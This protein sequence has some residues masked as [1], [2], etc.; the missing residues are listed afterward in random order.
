MNLDWSLPASVSIGAGTALFVGGTCF[1]A[2]AE[3]SSLRFVLDGHEQGV[4][5]HGM[6]RLD[7]LRA[8]HPAL[9]L[10][11]GGPLEF[12]PSS[13][14]DP[15][16]RSYRSGFWGLVRIGPDPSDSRLDLLLRAELD[17]GVEKTAS[18]ATIAVAARTASIPDAS[19]PSS[20]A[21]R[22]AICMATYD[23]PLDLFQR[24]IDSIRAQTHENWVCLISDD[25]SKPECS[26]QIAKVI[27]GDPRFVLSSSERRQ[28][29]YLNFERALSMV[30]D[31]A[32]HVTLA[33]Q[34]DFWYPEKLETLLAGMGGAH[35]IYSDARIVGRRGEE[36]SPTYWG[37]RRRNHDDLSALLMANC[38]TG[39]A[40][41]FRREVLT[42]ALPFP[43]AQFAHYH[44]HWL[45][46]VAGM[47]GRIDFIDRPLYDYVQHG[48]SALGHA[49]ATRVVS[50]RQ[51]AAKITG[52]PHER[53][54]FYRA[55]YFRD[56]ARVVAFAT[57]LDMRCA[58]R[59]SADDRRALEQF[60][61]LER[62]WPA[63]ARLGWRGARELGGQAE[64][65]G[66][67]W[68]LLT[69]LLWRRA[70]S[71]TAS[72]RPRRHLRLEAM[73]PIG[74]A[75]TAERRTLGDP[76]S[77]L[78]AQK[79]APLELAIARSAPRRVNVLIP[80]IDLEHFF[81]GYITKLN[82]AR[83]LAERGARVR[84]V[85][86]DRVGPLPRG[87]KRRVESYGGLAGLFDQIEVEFG[88]EA[89]RLEVSPEDSFV[90]TTWWTAHAAAAACEALGQD[91]FVYLIQEYEPMTFPW[92]ALSSLASQSYRYRHFAL[93]SSELLREYFQRH[94]I[95]VYEQGRAA[96]EACS[97][98]FQNAITNVTAPPGAQL[99]A[100]APRRLLFYA[101]PEPH[102][103]RNMFELGVLALARA[104]EEGAFR[105]GWEFRGIGTVA[106]SR[107]IDLGGDVELDLVPRAAQ[108]DYASLLAEHDV[109]LALM[110]SPHPSLVPIE[111]ASAGLLTVTN[112]FENKTA[113]ALKRISSNLIAGSPTVEGISEALQEAE[114]G[115]EQFERR[116]RG[117]N[118]A[119]SRDWSQ[120]FNEALL[121][122]LEDFLAFQ[123][124]AA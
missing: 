113:A 53:V 10:E 92:G 81:G 11:N 27:G 75:P 111:M 71:V 59:A 56:V 65:L 116:L 121:D 110:Y 102:A 119:W 63:M 37:R 4:W 32:T 17:S 22:V 61:A 7:H 43:P 107:R 47:L 78:V 109:G 55:R 64:T 38:V 106:G 83:R 52:D 8:L 97:A 104:L 24:Q 28:G 79:I 124:Q 49:A 51:R 15:A 105:R 39:A 58:F 69:A 82:L 68:S 29:F 85:T 90:A 21:P 96:G 87:W 86:V 50:W 72:R 88:R 30:G 41:L 99:A 66:A 93:F 118:V 94:R 95:G 9:D 1:D 100:R 108:R 77:R 23:P 33:D 84:L 31:D 36:I 60:L 34:D 117:T 35:L 120:S 45:A 19:F 26:E 13:A 6:P 16:M 122:R 123:A 3:I 42:Y 89:D 103:T 62:S 80:T 98:S 25:C 115:V 114:A 14:E 20:L 67:E 48:R 12:D 54:Q 76:A 91:G 46:L 44:D 73:P 101:R 2:E 40:S 74:L 112:T 57:I 5:A 70:V 18:L